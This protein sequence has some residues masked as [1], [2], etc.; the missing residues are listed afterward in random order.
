M[1]GRKRTR[2]WLFCDHCDQLLPKSTYYRHKD[3][4]LENHTADSEVFDVFNTDDSAPSFSE[5]DSLVV[6]ELSP[7]QPPEAELVDETRVIV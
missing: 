7:V 2:E 5:N 4:E 1:E 6:E 3:L